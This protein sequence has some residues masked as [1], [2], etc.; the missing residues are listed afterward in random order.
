MGSSSPVFLYY[1]SYFKNVS[2][3]ALCKPDLLWADSGT[4]LPRTL[5]VRVP[6][7]PILPL[8]EHAD[9]TRESEEIG[10]HNYP[11]CDSPGGAHYL[12]RGECS[13]QTHP[14]V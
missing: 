1:G 11:E 4:H 5:Q 6:K 7:I 8:L 9:E 13:Q 3:G 12:L 14:R 10:H 2:R